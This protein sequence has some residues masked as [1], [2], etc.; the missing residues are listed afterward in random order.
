MQT[1]EA[2]AQLRKTGRVTVRDTTIKRL[3]STHFKNGVSDA[4][5]EV[6][7]AN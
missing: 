2:A 1:C 4:H 5:F 3:G 6:S 7:L